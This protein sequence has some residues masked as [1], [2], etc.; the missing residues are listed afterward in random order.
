MTLLTDI[1]AVGLQEAPVRCCMSPVTDITLSVGY[2]LMNEFA[3]EILGIVAGKAQ[4]GG[5]AGQEHRGLAPVRRVATA[6]HTDPEGSVFFL[7]QEFNLY[8][9]VETEARR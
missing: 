4:L 5:L 8:V 9:A 7:T 2:G 3:L 1:V 6:A